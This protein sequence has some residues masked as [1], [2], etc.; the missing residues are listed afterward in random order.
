[1]AKKILGLDLGT[2]SIGWA[3][4]EQNFEI[5]ED[6]VIDLKEGAIIDIGS[7]I[8]PMS[9]DVLGD[10]DCMSSNQSELL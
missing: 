1:M 6:K 8:V 5:K 9:Q 7:R 10:F 2:N 3:L 4:V